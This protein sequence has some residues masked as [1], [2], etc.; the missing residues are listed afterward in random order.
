MHR[1]GG[2]LRSWRFGVDGVNV[3]SLQLLVEGVEYIKITGYIG[4]FAAGG[5]RGED[6]Y[7]QKCGGEQ[8]ELLH[9]DYGC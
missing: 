3:E 5:G 7:R 9:S 4:L 1:I 6:N 2:R 8:G